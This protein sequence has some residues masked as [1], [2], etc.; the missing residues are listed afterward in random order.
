MNLRSLSLS[1]SISPTL[2]GVNECK[3]KDNN[4]NNNNKG[5]WIWRRELKARAFSERI[6]EFITGAIVL[7]DVS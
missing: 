3:R 7:V 5:R 2:R 6:H 4:N 1:R